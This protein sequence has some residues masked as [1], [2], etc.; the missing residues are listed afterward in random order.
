VAAGSEVV[1]MA[2]RGLTLISSVADWAAFET[3]VAVIVAVNA[4][5]TEAGVL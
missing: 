2:G 5:V 4:V 3:E 1:A